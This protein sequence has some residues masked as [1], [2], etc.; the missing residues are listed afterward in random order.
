VPGQRQHITRLCRMQVV[1]L[2]WA[3]RSSKLTEVCV[4]C[5]EVCLPFGS[6]QY[7][8]SDFNFCFAGNILRPSLNLHSGGRIVMGRPGSADAAAAHPPRRE[9]PQTAGR[10]AA[11][12]GSGRAKDRQELGGILGSGPAGQAAKQDKVVAFFEGETQSMLPGCSR[13]LCGLH[14]CTCFFFSVTFRQASIQ[15]VFCS[16][17]SKVILKAKPAA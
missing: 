6:S 7:L 15:P 5:T 16:T 17:S 14:T 11:A 2:A 10:A 9:Q 8:A 12:A 13:P 4:G 3:A 1:R